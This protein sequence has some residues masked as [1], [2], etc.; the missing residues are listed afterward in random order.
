MSSSNLL[1]EPAGDLVLDADF[2]VVGSGAG[3]ATCAV[4]LAEAGF[5]VLV[6]EEGMHRPPAMR[7][8]SVPVTMKETFRDFGCLAAEGKALTPILQGRV[9]G[10]TTAI[11]AGIIWRV[12]EAVH[13]GWVERDPG[14][15]EA[16][17]WDVLQGHY[18][19]IEED[20]GITRVHRPTTGL[21]NLL[22]EKGCEALGYEGNVILRNAPDCQ[23]AGACLTMCP[24][25]NKLSMDRTYLPRAME[26]GARLLACCRVEGL[27]RVRDTWRVSATLRDPVEGQTRGSLVATARRG[28][29]LAAS[30]LQTPALL[31]RNRLGN[32][33]VGKGLMGHPGTGLVA[34]YPFVVRQWDGVHQGYECVQ[35]RDDGYKLE[36]LGLPPELA[37]IR[38]PGVGASWTQALGRLENTSQW[39]LA[40]KAEARGRVMPLGKGGVRVKY[41]PNQADAGKYQRGMKRLCDIAFAAGATKLYPGVHGVPKV[42]TDP[43]QTALITEKRLPVTAFSSLMTHLM[44]ACSMGSDDKT[45]A[46]GLD[47]Q[48]YGAPGITVAD[49]GLFPSNLGVNPQ[50]TIMAFA[51]QAA[52]RLVSARTP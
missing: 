2:V 6:L 25:D 11:N 1:A 15:A 33:R 8:L 20:L 18:D 13:Q 24:G 14:L 34:E 49:S 7:D 21:N 42:M 43:S 30:T 41:C 50:H 31:L 32:R 4:V 29:V 40:I 36:S 45:A 10:G 19:A 47:Y 3:G 26:A 48:V 5:D 35:F 28:V 38:M 17:P 27:K 46:V 52:Q 12:P 16:L 44:S 37:A 39:A 22:M 9:V 23:G 51:R